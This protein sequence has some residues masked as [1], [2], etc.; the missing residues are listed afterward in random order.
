MDIE[1]LAYSSCG[2]FLAGAGREE[3]HHRVKI[4]ES[5]SGALL[6]E[7]Q[8][9]GYGLAVAFSPNGGLLASA[10]AEG[11]IL[12]WDW[13]G[14]RT[15]EGTLAPWRPSAAEWERAWQAL[16]SAD[17]VAAW[18]AA[19]RFASAPE[20]AT[21]TLARHLRPAREMPD[22][23]L[24]TLLQTLDAEDFETRQGAEDELRKHGP[25]LAGQIERALPG[26]PLEIRRRLERL[27]RE[28][29]TSTE[30]L[31]TDRA[32]FALEQMGDAGRPLLYRLAEG[33]PEAE[34]TQLARA[35]L[36]RRK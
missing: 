15:P 20:Q 6:R 31:R 1:Q 2:R 8:M 30:A 25:G 16:G 21:L 5:R 9:P 36:K 10:G 19:W 26:Q 28:M 34:I 11:Q 35:A 12:I 3:E 14:R 27:L 22:D 32:L 7:F 4:W 18:D 17:G 24:A 33:V 23:R 13:S 29:R